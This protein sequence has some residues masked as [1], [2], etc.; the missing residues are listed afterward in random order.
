MDVLMRKSC[1]I[2]GNTENWETVVG[3]E[4]PPGDFTTFCW[5]SECNQSVTATVV[6]TRR[7]ASEEKAAREKAEREKAE[8]DAKAKADAEKAAA[9]ARA[10]ADA[11]AKAARAKI[12]QHARK[13]KKKWAASRSCIARR[14]QARTTVVAI[15]PVI[16]GW[17]RIPGSFRTGPGTP[18]RP[19]P[20]EAIAGCCA[21]AL[22]VSVARVGVGA[23]R[24]T[25]VPRCRA[26]LPGFE[27]GR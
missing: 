12:D 22:T 6:S 24:S 26:G 2:H 16:P 4:E 23:E 3:R 17:R 11:K 8:A 1:P 7:S 9:A 14:R 5:M 15:T 18:T 10:K 21:A 19:P 20:P 25:S 13:S 27:E